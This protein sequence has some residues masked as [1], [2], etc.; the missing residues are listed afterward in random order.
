LERLGRVL[1]PILPRT[2]MARKNVALAF[3]NKSKAE[4]NQ[5]VRSMWGYVARTLGEYVFLD[6]LFD[7]DPANP[8]QGRIEVVGAD[9]F[10]GIRD[11]KKPVII[12]TGHTGN[13]EIL[14]VAAATH[15][16][17]I[18][19]LFRPPNNQFLAKKVL[20]ARTTD[21]GH[22]IPSRAGAAWALADVLESDGVVGLLTDQAFT[23]GPHIEFL[24][25][26]ATANPLAAKLARQFDCDI[27][28][29]GCVR[30]PHGRFRL[31]LLDKIDIPRTK[32]GSLDVVE[33]TK[34]INAI[35]ENWIVEYPEQW[36][37]LHNRWKIKTSPL[38]KWA[39][40]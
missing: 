2:K 21:G 27:Y 37:W 8:E 23:K 20:K 9:N 30:L 38:K 34:S 7:Y 36:L 5:I 40:K 33:T 31:E 25:R 10:V 4:V 19:A 12:F 28:P 14:P 16:L 11:A 13:W 15:D 17:H 32:D 18:T 1:S 6:K 3:P 26:T 39:K 22:L 29:A 35:I 24:G